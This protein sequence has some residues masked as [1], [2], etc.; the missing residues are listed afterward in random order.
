VV[1]EAGSPSPRT[2][3]GCPTGTALRK[4]KTGPVQVVDSHTEEQRDLLDH[5]YR[6]AEEYG[7]PLWCQDEVGAYQAIPQPGA[8]WCPQG[9][10]ARQPPEQVRGGTAKLLPLVRPALGDVRARGVAS[11]P[12]T[13]LHPWLTTDLT[14][15][16][17]ALARR[18]RAL[19][20]PRSFPLGGSAAKSGPT[21][22]LRPCG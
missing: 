14:P 15:V 16:L 20:P 2:R 18:P 3:T 13:V 12:H 17:R 22:T 10:R 4:R 5:A 21:T 19:E 11:V 9:D 7:L 1:Q 6:L 8:G